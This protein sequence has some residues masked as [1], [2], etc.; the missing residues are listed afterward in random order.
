MP[1]PNARI[2][3]SRDHRLVI[4]LVALLI[5]ACAADAAR[6]QDGEADPTTDQREW[7]YSS[8][9][10]ARRE[11][12]SRDPGRS[13]WNEGPWHASIA[14]GPAWFGGDNIS[15]SVGFV[16]EVKLARDLTDEVYA[17][18]SY[19]LLTAKTEP[20]PDSFGS[21]ESHV[22]H[23]LALGVGFRFEVTPEVELFLEPRAGILFGGDADAAPAGLLSGGIEVSVTEGIAIRF[24]LTGLLTDSTLSTSG[25]DGELESGVM[26]TLGISFEF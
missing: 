15:D 19:D 8:R 18:A 14:A 9:G 5:T 17:L 24:A 4:L 12:G 20:D 1:H 26:G 10:P 6:A 13:W 7:N 21:D 11:A 3:A 25:P 16:A 2:H 23:T 22:L